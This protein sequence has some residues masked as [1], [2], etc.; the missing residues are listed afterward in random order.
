MIS[1]GPTKSSSSTSGKI[2]KPNAIGHSTD[3]S[4]HGSAVRYSSHGRGTISKGV[5]S[6]ARRGH[7]GRIRKDAVAVRD[8]DSHGGGAVGPGLP[9]LHPPQSGAQRTTSACVRADAAAD[10]RTRRRPPARHPRRRRQSGH[11]SHG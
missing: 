10:A 11:P 4:N 2:R 3:T 6:G 7:F 9:V 1:H 8:D 5:S